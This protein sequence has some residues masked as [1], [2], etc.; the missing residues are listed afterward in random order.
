MLLPALPWRDEMPKT[1][2]MARKQARLVAHNVL[3][4][5]NGQPRHSFPWERIRKNLIIA[6]PDVGGQT[7]MVKQGGKVLLFGSWPLQLRHLLDRS[8]FRKH[9]SGERRRKEESR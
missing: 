8:Y 1:A 4:Q 3:A 5:A 9:P 7:V 6:M 2:G